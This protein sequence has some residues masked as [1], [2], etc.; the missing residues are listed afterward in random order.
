MEDLK[1]DIQEL[2]NMLTDSNLTQEERNMLRK[3]IILIKTNVKLSLLN[4]IISN[5]EEIKTLI[6]GIDKLLSTYENELSE[7]NDKITE[8][9]LKSKI[10][11]L[12]AIKKSIEDNSYEFFVED[13][14][15]DIKEEQQLINIC[16][17]ALSSDYRKFKTFFGS[18][19]INDKTSNNGYTVNVDTIDAIF[20]I[21][22]NHD[23]NVH[24]NS[25]VAVYN[26]ERDLQKKIDQTNKKID[27]YRL[28]IENRE[29]IKN[30]IKK[31]I[32]VL[33]KKE[34]YEPCQTRYQQ[35]QQIIDT[36]NESSLFDRLSQRYDREKR[37]IENEKLI[38]YLAKEKP[39][40]TGLEKQER[41]A[42]KALTDAG[43]DSILDEFTRK[44]FCKDGKISYKVANASLDNIEYVAYTLFV[45]TLKGISKC[46]K[47]IELAEHLISVLEAEKQKHIAK[48]SS[49]YNKMDERGKDLVDNHLNDCTNIVELETSDKKYNISPILSAYVLRVISKIK[50][51]DFDKLNDM[52][53]SG[54][55]LDALREEYNL[56]IERKIGETYHSVDE[57]KKETKPS[58]FNM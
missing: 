51:I 11:R 32:R 7:A 27:L 53:D 23:L 15:G 4:N 42:A 50:K 39:L 3:L 17:L 35:N 58:I 38:E 54:I 13:I 16:S 47:E 45:E 41:E 43:L 57:I 37:E 44:I 22:T 26:K 31:H 9:R 8:G 2:K 24:I 10:R 5:K 20:E 14:V 46:E 1:N 52:V 12:T 34:E 30:Y 55:D 33:I 36:I 19:I 25:Y 49:I 21:I 56:L 40:L 29:L 28:C 48:K 6:T 18:P